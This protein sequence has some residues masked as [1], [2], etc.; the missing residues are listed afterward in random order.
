PQPDD[1][2]DIGLVMGGS[3]LPIPGSGYVQLAD[4][5][6][7]NHVY[8]GQ[9]TEFYGATTS[10]PFGEGLFTPEG[11]YPL[12][13]VHTLPL[14]YP[15]GGELGLPTDATSVGQ[16]I[17]IL[18]NQIESNASHDLLSTVFG[19]S[20]SSTLAGLTMEQLT[21]DGVS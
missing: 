4:G 19:Y 5:L 21:A 18:A 14:N 8:P 1:A 15:S 3:G 16:G 13:G 7:L 11:L 17:T 20:Q 6:Y 12:T 10:N 2:P 9:I